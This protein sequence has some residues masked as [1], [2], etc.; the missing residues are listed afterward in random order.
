M[1][2]TLLSLLALFSILISTS[3]AIEVNENELKSTS[4]EVIQ[5][6]N[7]T[8]PHKVIESAT[9]ISGIGESL[10]KAVSKDINKSG[11]FGS[12]KYSVIHAIDE[13]ETGK[14][15]ADI[16]LINPN[17][18]V[19][20]IK[21]LRRIIASYLASAYDYNIQDANTIAT[22]I[23]VYNAVYRGKMDI[24]EGKYKN[25][26]TKNLTQSKC[27]LSTKWSEWPGASQIVIPLG[28]LQNGVSTVDTSVISDKNVVE[29]MQEDDDKGID[30]RKQMVEIKEREAEALQEKADQKQEE[31]K[32]EKQV[33]EEKKEEA[34]VAQKEADKAKKE[35][36][37]AQKE[38]D[39][40][41]S[42]KQ[43]QQVA[44]EKAVEAEK[45]QKEAEE[46]QKEADEAEERADA[47]QKEADMAEEKAS[48]KQQEAQTE[49]TQIAEDQQ[50][51]VNKQIQEANSSSVIGLI[52]TNEGLQLSGMVKVNGDTGEAIKTSPVTVI[53][54]RTILPV[55]NAD[56]DIEDGSNIDTANLFMA[57]C[58]ENGGNS[59]VKLC[60][61]DTT[62][63]EIQKESE[64]ELSEH[65]VLVNN[66]NDYYV[67]IKDSSKNV[68][69]KYDKSLNLKLKSDV[70]VNGSTP[71]TIT[72]KGLVVTDESGKIA[73]LN[74]QDLSRVSK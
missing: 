50:A 13:N 29:S 65:S 7:Y 19:D 60:L 37:Q 23:T 24:F 57:V 10:G 20:H 12:G 55:S 35:A 4:S 68:V 39:E 44:E 15:D 11:T 49:R 26:V 33:A 66:G 38:A 64:E 40:D 62:K 72:D 16:I 22:F 59:A 51:V 32:K 48:Q 53:R 54:G 6:E 34:K 8:G 3:Y 74:I 58:G 73:L 17:A 47:A 56:I 21:N 69:A 27:G 28:D 1:K 71:I 41:P 31:A 45:A 18:T 30:E 43:K 67:V 9:A 5:F 36:E 25:V 2:K 70:A 42:N 52:I 63:M 14:L 46:S 61:L